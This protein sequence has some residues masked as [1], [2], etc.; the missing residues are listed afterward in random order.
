MGEPTPD[1]FDTYE[2]F[3]KAYV[4]WDNDQ[5]E[6]QKSA[7]TA[8]ARTAEAER[9]AAEAHREVLNTWKSRADE[10]RKAFADYDEVMES[11]GDLPIPAHMNQAILHH[12]DGPRLAYELAKDRKEAERIAAIEDPIRAS[13]AIGAYAAKFTQSEPVPKSKAPITGA[14]RPVT[15][16]RNGR[17]TGATPDIHNPDLAGDYNEWERVRR[18]QLK[19]R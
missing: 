12:P 15:P 4:R 6:Q 9:K 19:D 1:D 8:R 11:G 5:R 17:A 18:A 16:L 2:E 7:E 13:V 10:T 14:P 3:T